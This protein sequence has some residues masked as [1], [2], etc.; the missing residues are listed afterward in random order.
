MV[1]L[2]L[3]SCRHFD[4]ITWY[5]LDEFGLQHILGGLKFHHGI[6]EVVGYTE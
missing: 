6:V 3:A 1:A 2:M 5:S 4:Q